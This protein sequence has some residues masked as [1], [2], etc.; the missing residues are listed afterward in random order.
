MPRR[1]ENAETAAAG[2]RV[3]RAIGDFLILA[4]LRESGGFAMAVSEA[5]IFAARDEAARTEGCCSV[6]KARRR[7]PPGA[8]PSRTAGSP[9]ATARCCSTAPRASNIR[10][11]DLMET[12][13]RTH[14]A[15]AREAR[16][17]RP[18]TLPLRLS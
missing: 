16:P 11:P 3:P 9:R 7:S 5:E 1:W 4:A 15:A 18:R 8:A 17:C 13:T 12:S 6:P 14:R 2:I 10:C